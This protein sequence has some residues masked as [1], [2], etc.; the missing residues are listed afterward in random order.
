LEVDLGDLDRDLDERTLESVLVDEIR[1]KS[2]LFHPRAARIEECLDSEAIWR[3]VQRRRF[4]LTVPQCPITSRP[5]ALETDCFHC[6]YLW[7]ED[8][9]E[10]D[11]Y[12]PSRIRCT[13]HLKERL[14][15][16]LSQMVSAEPR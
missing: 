10:Q 6:R 13:G 11:S 9:D 1:R 3:P 15:P 7:D 12:F 2:W 16:I 8:G 14:D 5:V 4:D